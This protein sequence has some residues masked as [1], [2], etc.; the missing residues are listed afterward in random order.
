MHTRTN[1]FQLYLYFTFKCFQI[2]KIFFTVFCSPLKS[3]GGTYTYNTNLTE[4]GYI[5]GTISVF[6]CYPGW[7]LA[8]P[9]YGSRRTCVQSGNWNG[10]IQVGYNNHRKNL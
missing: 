9:H 3:G 4:H 6:H 1:I 8:L 5:Y 7:R 2:F 10:R